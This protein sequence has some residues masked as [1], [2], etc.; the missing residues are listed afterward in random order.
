MVENNEMHTKVYAG[1]GI[2]TPRLSTTDNGDTGKGNDKLRSL[3]AIITE[4]NS[5]YEIDD[6]NNVKEGSNSALSTPVNLSI[7]KF[8][9]YSELP[10]PMGYTPNHK[11]TNTLSPQIEKYKMSSPVLTPLYM[12][13]IRRD[14]AL[15][16]KIDDNV[17][18]TYHHA[19][20]HRII[21]ELPPLPLAEKQ[22]IASLPTMNEE[23]MKF[24][25]SIDT[26]TEEEPSS[27]EK[28]IDGYLVDDLEKKLKFEMVKVIGEGN[29]STV[30]LFERI[31]VT[32]A[33]EDN[34]LQQVA[35]K[36]IKYPEELNNPELKGTSVYTDIMSRFETSLT[37]EL[38]VLKSIDHPCIIKL[39]AINNKIFLASKKPVQDILSKN[40]KLPPLDL[41]CSYCSG[42]DILGTAIAMAG[43][44]ELWFIQ[45]IFSEL[46]LAVK[47]LHEN[48]IIH[49]D[50]KLENIL[51]KYPMEKILEMK[52]SNLLNNESIIELGDFGLCKQLYPGEMCTTRCGSE[53]YVSPEI[54]MGIEYDGKLSDTWAMG[55]ILYGLLENRLPFDPLPNANF[56]QRSRSTAH[57]IAMFEWKWSKMLDI[58]SSAKEIVKNTLIRKNSRWRIEQIYNS[59][60][61]QEQVTKLTYI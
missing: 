55:V 33:D 37:R 52:E 44:L 46:T 53:D 40:D 16:R 42:G 15:V 45:R 11:A 56:R 22:R 14:P 21:S 24:G 3:H 50:L 58:E 25:A 36:S 13:K 47:Y 48:N 7:P 5:D 39:Y 17:S 35:V 49:R 9:K 30:Y 59:E 41:I 54:L 6:A 8:D 19:P 23:P 20:Q 61:I 26:I 1:L 28:Q 4:N 38:S 2:Q 34:R 31:G 10:T 18:D 32:N 60:Y 43:K 29:F 12:S 57:R 27:E 51:L